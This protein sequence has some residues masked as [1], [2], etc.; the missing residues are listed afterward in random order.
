M[1]K[2]P[3]CASINSSYCENAVIRNC[4]QIEQQKTS[5]SIEQIYSIRLASQVVR[6]S[7]SCIFSITES[8]VAQVTLQNTDD[9]MINITDP[10]N[11]ENFYKCQGLSCFQCP[12]P[13]G[14]TFNPETLR[15]DESNAVCE[16]E[17]TETEIA[18]ETT[19]TISTDIS[20]STITTEVPGERVI[21]PA[22]TNQKPT[23][24]EPPANTTNN[25][26]A[27]I[28]V[29]VAA[30]VIILAALVI[31]FCLWQRGIFPLR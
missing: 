20:I 17:Q 15:C 26:I 16:C 9:A 3:F 23:T 18:I 5:C 30:T 25:G 14:Q 2:L 21:P 10:R 28:A 11:C 13:A 8:C 12:C 1:M 19:T 6:S 22:N 29:I 4:Y 7:C 31:G 24:L 27:I